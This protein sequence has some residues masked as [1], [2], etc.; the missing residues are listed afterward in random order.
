[1]KIVK[2]FAL[3]LPLAFVAFAHVGSPDIYLDGQAG[4]YKLFITIRPPTVIP[5]VAEIEVRAQNSGVKQLTVVPVPLNRAGNNL[6]PVPD[7]LKVS[8]Q[9]P[10]EFTGSLWIMTPGSWQVRIAAAGSDGSG[11][12]AVPLPAY[13]TRTKKMGSGL[14]AI[15]LTMTILLAAGVVLIVGA[16]VRE[17]QLQPGERPEPARVSRS[18][19][20]MIKASVVVGLLIAF[21]FWWWSSAERDYRDKIYKPLDM[22]AS[23][24]GNELTLKLS[25]P[26]WLRLP[27]QKLSRLSPTV[28]VRTIDDLVPDHNHLMHLYAIREPGLDEVY[29]LHPEQTSAG[30]FRLHLP[31][32]KPGPYR[33]YAD[34]V[35][36][37]GF[38]ETPVGR[39]T[40]PDHFTGK[41]LEGDDASGSATA[42]ENASISNTAF[43]LPDG[44]TMEWLKPAGLI[45]V[46]EGNLFRFRLLDRSG[47]PAGDMHYY[48][49]ML[50]HAAFV[51]TDGSRF[52][53]I[54][55]TGS[56]SMASYMLA[57]NQLPASKK[58]QGDMGM[59]GMDMSGMDMPGMD[60]SSMH[61]G[62]TGSALPSEVS[63]PY[64]FPAAGRY[65]IF[66]QMKHGETV[67]TGAFDLEVK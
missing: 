7:T 43:R 37:N 17:G 13:A 1:M 4:P 9:D 23:L 39:V 36:A 42:W 22:A 59:D 24:N 55:P 25:D 35:H 31:S 61:S 58:P 45:R 47:K 27:G 16:S 67:E 38:P 10:Q 63:F 51:K 8:A 15:L 6:A 66:V 57:E 14:G 34:I 44:Y 11:E 29:H 52:A 48:M 26:G 5:G 40:I 56:V 54:H 19:R 30:V 49:G 64:G 21:G 41:T 53:H 20:A 33:L 60:M 65:R 3:L 62:G 32:M 28:F 12:V 50:G 2:A 46:R 18:Y